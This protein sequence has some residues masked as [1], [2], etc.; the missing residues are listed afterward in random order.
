MEYKKHFD[1]LLTTVFL[2]RW[3]H[4]KK[5]VSHLNIKKNDKT[6]L[7]EECDIEKIVDTLKD[8]LKK[9]IVLI[10]HMGELLPTELFI[11]Y[12]TFELKEDKD[13][14]IRNYVYHLRNREPQNY[15]KLN[16]S[17]IDL[18]EIDDIRVF[19]DNNTGEIRLDVIKEGLELDISE[20]GRGFQY[21]TLILTKLLFSKYEIVLIDEPDTNMHVNLIRH[22]IHLLLEIKELQ[23]VLSTH[24]ESVINEVNTKNIRYIRMNNY[25]YS[26]FDSTKVITKEVLE[27]LGITISNSEVA[28]IINSDAIVLCEGPDDKRYLPLLIGKIENRKI[29][30]KIHFLYT[31]GKSFTHTEIMD[32]LM[33]WNKPIILIQDRD[34]NSDDD[35]K[36]KQKSNYELYYLKKREI[37]NYALNYDSL[38][39]LI[40][41]NRVYLEQKR[42][43]QKI[44]SLASDLR[45]KIVVLKTLSINYKSS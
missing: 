13:R 6:A 9:K 37:E 12:N 19:L 32:E 36:D 20:M 41:K 18:F 7:V 1:N 10:K 15:I 26:V 5:S 28:R 24:N 16:T 42:V 43:T 27:D 33:K 23:I 30:E 34:E 38:L 22:F 40:N 11:P 3:E 25:F 17:L 35:I 29:L 4:H 21:A 2:L 14:Y 44:F 8:N 39:R 31:G 45:I